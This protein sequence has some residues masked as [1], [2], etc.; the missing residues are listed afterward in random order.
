MN[1][2]KTIIM[3]SLLGLIFAGFSCTNNEDKAID[4]NEAEVIEQKEVK[5]L[6]DDIQTET[7]E[8]DENS[9]ENMEEVNVPA[10]EEETTEILAVGGY[11]GTGE[12]TR[13]YDGEMFIHT[14]EANISDPASGKFYEG[15]LVKKSPS[16]QF[17]STGKMI[18][19][20]DKYYLEYKAS[21]DKN[22]FNEVVITEE[23]ESNGLD[24]NPE[25]HVL[26]GAF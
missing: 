9:N 17:F 7:L 1:K 12:A 13:S 10:T 21:E 3:L 15:W 14:V 20:D 5:D 4:T 6:K 23:T 26:E 22:D 16:L 19:R 18:K 11:E 8:I 25:A 24:G 2:T